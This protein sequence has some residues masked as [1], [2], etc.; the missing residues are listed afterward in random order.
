[1]TDLLAGMGALRED[2]P[3]VRWV[4][5]EQIHLTLAFFGE[6]PEQRLEG[7]SARLSRLAGRTAAP[8]LALGSLG[9]FGSP[10]HQQVLWVAVVEVLKR[11]PAQPQEA[12]SRLRHFAGACAAAGRREGLDVPERW[13]A[14]V[15]LARVSSDRP[16]V[17][18]LTESI[19]VPRQPWVAHELLLI[20]SRLGAGPSRRPR[21][22]PVGSWALLDANQLPGA[23][24]VRE[25]HGSAS[26][27]G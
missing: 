24:S 12:D 21:Y 27:G 11:A 17:G 22:E 8:T 14:H 5:A 16:S 18:A 20:R 13:K 15:T 19:E 26:A 9:R 10:R 3:D 1:M 7:L 23:S 4:P 25:D 2:R 6:V